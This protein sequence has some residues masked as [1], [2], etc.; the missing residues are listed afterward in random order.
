MNGSLDHVFL[1]C[2]RYFSFD[3]NLYLDSKDLMYTP[4]PSIFKQVNQRVKYSMLIC[5][6]KLGESS[7]EI[8]IK[9]ECDHYFFALNLHYQ[10]SSNM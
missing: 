1:E 10:H 4:N 7:V 2:V 5:Y 8:G 3:L 9:R 6:I